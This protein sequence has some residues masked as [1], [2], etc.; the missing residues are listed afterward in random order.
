MHSNLVI[1]KYYSSIIGKKYKINFEKTLDKVSDIWYNKTASREG[2]K[3]P[4]LSLLK[5]LLKMFIQN[6]NRADGKAPKPSERNAMARPKNPDRVARE[7]MVTRTIREFSFT[8]RF[9]PKGG[10]SIET[11][12]ISFYGNEQSATR[13]ATAY[14]RTLGT[15]IDEVKLIETKERL[16]GQTI[17]KFIENAIVLENTEE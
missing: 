1:I 16:L 14:A 8:F 9:V 17:E 7:E 2:E 10:N 6:K 13:K 5:G 11:Q 3:P 12:R 15:L 4:K